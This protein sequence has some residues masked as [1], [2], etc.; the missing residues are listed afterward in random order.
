M[1]NHS[2]VWFSVVYRRIDVQNDQFIQILSGLKE[3]EEVVS[4]PF[5]AI[6]KTLKDGQIV[7]KVAKEKLFEGEKK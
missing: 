2:V 6:S 5:T 7:E 3:G 4:G 1:R